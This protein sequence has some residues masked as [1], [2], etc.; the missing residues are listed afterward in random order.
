M[1]QIR[2]TCR[3]SWTEHYSHSSMESS[4]R[5]ADSY[6]SF[7][8]FPD[9]CDH[10]SAVVSLQKL[11]RHAGGCCFASLGSLLYLSFF[12]KIRHAGHAVQGVENVG[13]WGRFEYI[14]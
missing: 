7:L 13:V 6:H 10:G 14:R 3:N 11:V 12:I 8:G 4:Y 9:V 1:V 5:E 2:V